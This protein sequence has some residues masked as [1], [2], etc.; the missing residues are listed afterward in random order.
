MKIKLYITVLI[1]TTVL[2][3]QWFERNNGLDLGGGLLSAMDA[4]S[5]T[6]AVLGSSGTIYKTVNAGL[7][8]EEAATP[9]QFIYYQGRLAESII[10]IEA[11]DINHIWIVT[12]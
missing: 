2:N 8:W 10:D 12:S 5:S 9:P 1:L 4:I 11:T 7:S 3:A 6:E